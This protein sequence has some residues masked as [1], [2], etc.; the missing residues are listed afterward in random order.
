MALETLIQAMAYIPFFRKQVIP[1]GQPEPGYR[2]NQD[3]TKL[4]ARVVV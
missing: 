1:D 2:L 4:H 3:A